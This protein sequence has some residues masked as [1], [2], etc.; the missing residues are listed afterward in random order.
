MVII[1][2]DTVVEGTEASCSAESKPV[3]LGLI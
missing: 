1:Y 2:R 3:N